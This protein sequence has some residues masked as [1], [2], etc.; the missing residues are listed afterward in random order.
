[1]NEQDLHTIKDILDFQSEMRGPR[2]HSVLEFKKIIEAITTPQAK[3][4]GEAIPPIQFMDLPNNNLIQKTV[5]AMYRSA[6][7]KILDKVIEADHLRGVRKVINILHGKL[8][9]AAKAVLEQYDNNTVITDLNKMNDMREA[10]EAIENETPR[11][12]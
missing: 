3:P 11:K 4:Q 12:G 8:L 5:S 6:V 7:D 9:E 1:M 2:H 10:I